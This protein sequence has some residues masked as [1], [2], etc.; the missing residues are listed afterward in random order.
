MIKRL[1]GYVLVLG[2]LSLSLAMGVASGFFLG[3]TEDLPNPSPEEMTSQ[4]QNLE[5]ISTLT[6]NDGS[7][8]DE[9]RS[10][11]VRKNVQLEE[12]SPQ[13]V[14][15]LVAT[16][17][18]HFFKHHGVVP[19]AILRAVLSQ[20]LGGS[21]SGGSTITQQLVKQRFLSNEVSFERK[22]KEMLLANRLEN[23]FSKEQ[24]LESYLNT[25]P[26]GRNNKGENIAGI[27]AATEG[28]FGKSADQV[29]L[30]QAAF[31]VGMP[32]NPYTYTPYDSEG[33]LKSPEELNYGV[34]RMQEVLDRMRLENY[35]SQADYEKA[36]DYPIQNDFIQAESQV[37]E[38]GSSTSQKN[39][40]LY[41]QVEKQSLKLLM[42]RFMAMDGVSEEEI[43]ADDNLRSEY[44]Q[45]ADSYYRNGGL[46]VKTTVDP[47]IYQLLNQTVANQAGS[48]GQTYMAY[49]NNPETDETEAIPLP[50]QTGNVLIENA[51]GRILGFVGGIDFDQNQVDHAF[52]MRRSPGSMFKPL[53]TYGPAIQEGL[54]FPSTLIADTPIRIQQADGSYYEPS[55]YGNNIS[56]QL[57]TFRHAL[58]NSLNNPT[59]YLYQHL[60][61]HGVDIQEYVDRLGLDQSVTENEVK[62]NVALSIGGTQTGPTVVE[63]AAAFATFANGGQ[64]ISPYLIESI[65]DSNG[66]LIYQ[67]QNHQE[68]VFDKESSD[69]MVDVLKDTHRTGTFQPYS[70]GLNAFSDI[71]MKTGTSEDFNDHWIGGS[72][73]RITLMSWI[74]YDNTYQRHT[75]NDDGNASFGNPV[76]RHAKHWLSLLNQL[77]NYDPQMM[78]SSETFSP[79]QHLVR[80]KVVKETGTL[81]GSF[82]GPY[83]TQY[84]IPISQAS[85][86]GIFPNQAA[87]PKA[88][89]DFAIGAS[90]EEQ[91]HALEP[92]RIKNNSQVNQKVNE[93]LDLYEQTH[94]K[95]N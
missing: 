17:D 1:L 73:P 79:S 93:I 82:T 28:I 86:E 77:N 14:H 45:R 83:N 18:E 54:A 57:V 72:S 19:S 38:T 34:E 8:I 65:S 32:Q 91:V 20:V 78:G 56:N 75:L 62:D 3:L 15:G 35:I 26:F 30:P 49:Q 55:N 31:L 39:T 71:Y 44:Q 85:E 50:V 43:Q 81:P 40:Y 4:I 61:K 52:D 24:I 80:Q 84:R 36:K 22:A 12:I 92:Y 94:Q 69:I 10:D 68:P 47:N 88:Q 27:E 59:I 58:A 66:N 33:Q 46:T 67:H 87:I 48:L 21:S 74:G 37:D 42:Q 7:L 9:V 16:E 64:S 23:Y 95:E 25:S 13:I 63:L 51:S 53:L 29:N 2:L 70:G 60:L 89:F 76:E 41:Q 5:E 6:Y 90:L 11:L